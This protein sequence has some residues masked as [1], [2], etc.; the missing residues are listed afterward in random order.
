MTD[1]PEPL[2][3]LETIAHFKYLWW[4]IIYNMHPAKYTEAKRTAAWAEAF[5][6]RSDMVGMQQAWKDYNNGDN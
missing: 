2:T 6:M 5:Q 4:S 3:L 1:L